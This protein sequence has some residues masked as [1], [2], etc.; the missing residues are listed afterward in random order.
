MSRKS[1]DINPAPLVP[2]FAPFSS[3][4]GRT[5]GFIDVGAGIP[6]LKTMP[7]KGGPAFKVCSFDF[8]SAGVTWGDDNTI[9]FA[10]LNRSTGLFRVQ[11]TGGQPEVLTTPDVAHGEGD[12]VWPQFLPQARAVLFTIIPPVD[13]EEPSHI[14]VLD[15]RTGRKKVLNLPGA[16]QA[17]YTSSGHLIYVAASTLFAVPFDLD[18][19]DVH[20]TPTT[21]PIKVAT[22]DSGTAEFDIGRDGTLAYIPA[23]ARAGAPRTLVWIDRAG[24]E[25]PVAGSQARAYMHPR[26]S[27]DGSRLS[28]TIAGQVHVWNFGRRS[29]QRVTFESGW[30]GA[31]VWVDNR[32]VAYLSTTVNGRAFSGSAGKLFR[33][34][35]DGNRRRGGAHAGSGIIGRPGAL[36]LGHPGAVVRRCGRPPRLDDVKERRAEAHAQRTPPHVLVSDAER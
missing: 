9:V 34:A 11:A 12:H 22:N 10:T 14:A 16:S 28:V 1:D 23:G 24:R 27:P 32:S 36:I 35:V 8:P 31:P 20:G 15:L 29:L 21:L 7:A 25:E 19:L 26:L 5:I 33:R 30:Q 18:R 13:S 17:R 3:P 4:D 6:E 2:G